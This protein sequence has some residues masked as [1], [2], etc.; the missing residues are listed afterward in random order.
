MNPELIEADATPAISAEDVESWTCSRCE[1][2]VSFTSQAERPRLPTTWAVEGDSLYC[3]SCRRE[4]AGDAGVEHLDEGAPSDVRLRAR[5]QARIE[6][7]IR[8]DPERPDNK[9]AKACSTS[10]LKVR[11]VR[12]QLGIERAPTV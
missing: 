2:T 10:T 3:L 5:S 1:M 9:I 8:R 6:F 12:D 4:M 7:E 11:R